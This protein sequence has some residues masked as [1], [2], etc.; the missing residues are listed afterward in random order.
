MYHFSEQPILALLP[1]QENQKLTSGVRRTGRTEDASPQS[2]SEVRHEWN[3]TSSSPI[4]L[5]GVSRDKLPS[6]IT[7][8]G[9][10]LGL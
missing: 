3:C 6:T 7:I 2:S 5:N 8:G 10:N 9:E 1:T 4:Y